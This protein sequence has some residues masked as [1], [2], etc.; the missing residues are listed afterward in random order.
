MSDEQVWRARLARE[1]A[2]RQEAERLL[3]S[4][5]LELYLQ[6][7]ELERATATLEERVRRRTAELEAALA[8]LT[9]AHADLK[10]SNEALKLANRQLNKMSTTDELTNVAN[11]R[12]FQQ[13]ASAEI[14]RIKRHGGQLSLL[15]LDVDL[16]KR[17][18][19]DHGHVAG[20]TVL[21]EL[22]NCIK[23]SIRSADLV[24]RWGGEEFVVLLPECG[25]NTLPPVAEKL[26]ARIAGHIFSNIRSLTVSIGGAVYCK[27]ES[28]DAWMTRADTAL[29]NA[30]AKG[31]D[32]VELAAGPQAGL[33]LD[34]DS[35]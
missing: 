5:A 24:A 4:K 19:D 14:E 35:Q 31:R 1:R 7:A 10:L 33:R 27:P 25:S 11:R 32:T 18:N 16:F 3:E 9:E 6:N 29:Y 26:R 13:R 12:Y 20:D 15:I 17:I 2:A 34:G 22:A 23:I 8:E 28:L 21:V 30:K